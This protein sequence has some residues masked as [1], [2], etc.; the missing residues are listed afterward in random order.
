MN[1]IIRIFAIAGGTIP[2][3]II[4]IGY[5]ELYVDIQ[6]IPFTTTYGFC[7]WPSR[8]LLIGQGE[9]LTISSLVTLGISILLNIF[10]YTIAGWIVSVMWKLW[11][12]WNQSVQR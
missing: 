11:L 7:L 1:A 2:I 8:V 6:R 4:I 10:L 12:H 3:L 5:I 9:D